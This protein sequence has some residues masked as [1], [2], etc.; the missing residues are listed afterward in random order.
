MN[1]SQL[2]DAL[3]DRLGDRKTATTAVDALLQI[4]VDTV[5]SGDSVSLAGFGVFESRARAAR[6]GRNPRTGE[7]VVVPATTVPAFRP[8][9][10][11]RNAIAGAATPPADEPAAAEEPAAPA[12]AP[13]A[14]R[15]RRASRESATN[16]AGDGAA[17]NGAVDLSSMPTTTLLA[18][19]PEA[20]EEKPAKARK[21]AVK[22]DAVKPASKKAV[23]KKSAGKQPAAAKAA[24]KDKASGKKRKKSK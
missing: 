14:P 19:P 3:A 6:T 13:A 23:E 9:T 15:R 22:A 7:S 20:V 5:R 18:E 4:V 21:A 8:G 11:F 1:K 17:L 10:G 24:K 2:V 12:E 16:G